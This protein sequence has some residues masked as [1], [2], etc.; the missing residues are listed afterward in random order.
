MR[1]IKSYPHAS[2]QELYDFL[3]VVVEELCTSIDQLGFLETEELE[4]KKTVWSA[5]PESSI[6]TR[7]RTATYAASHIT[8]QIKTLERTIQYL[9]LERQ[10]LERLIDAR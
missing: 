1:S 5:D 4:L 8:T 10:L 6:Q 9:H 2:S 3:T 7:D